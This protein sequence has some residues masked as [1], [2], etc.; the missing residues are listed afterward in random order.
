MSEDQQPTPQPEV[1]IRLEGIYSA[2]PAWHAEARQELRA[3]GRWSRMVG[4]G[5]VTSSKDPS[6]WEHPYLK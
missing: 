5:A 1:E 6:E 4:G 3:K 2:G